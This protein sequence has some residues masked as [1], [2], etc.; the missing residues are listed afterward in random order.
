MSVISGVAANISGSAP[1]TSATA[2]RLRS[3]TSWVANRFSMRWA[4]PITPTTG[5]LIA[6]NP[7]LALAHYQGFAA[8]MPAGRGRINRSDR[9]A[10]MLFPGKGLFWIDSLDIGQTRRPQRGRRCALRALQPWQFCL[11]P[12]RDGLSQ[13]AAEVERPQAVRHRLGRNRVRAE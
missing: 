13:H 10:A 9:K 3:P 11:D 4:F 5:L 7:V 1:A 2:R 6:I 8:I 12:A